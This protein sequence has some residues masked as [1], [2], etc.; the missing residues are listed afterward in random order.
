ME[1]ANSK[2]ESI[3][4][5]GEVKKG[6]AID[7]KDLEKILSESGYGMDDIHEALKDI[8]MEEAH[9]SNKK[10]EEQ[11]E[12]KM[13]DAENLG[14]LFDELDDM[15]PEKKKVV[16]RSITSIMMGTAMQ[17]SPTQE[18]FKKITEEH[19]TE[20]M[21]TSR[22]QMKEEYKESRH[23]RVF[24]GIIFLVA[25]IFFIVIIVIL[26]NN[27]AVMEKIIYS[28]IGMVMGILGGYGYAKNKG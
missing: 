17:E 25:C 2:A 20:F 14:T 24:S 28:A 18:I 3:E 27:P 4:K 23:R 11:D 15:P 8:A 13:V 26:K 21:A 5:K 7:K 10:K 6:K 16:E 19:I 12:A 22:E 1:E 9:E